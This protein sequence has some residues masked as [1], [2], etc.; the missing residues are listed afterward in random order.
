M[1]MSDGKTTHSSR[2]VVKGC[3]ED[4]TNA[5]WRSQTDIMEKIQKKEENELTDVLHWPYRIE[6]HSPDTTAC[7]RYDCIL[8]MTI[9]QIATWAPILSVGNS[10]RSK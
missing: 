8:L 5:G 7:P 6:H 3:V 4:R 1:L 10:S 2:S 9:G